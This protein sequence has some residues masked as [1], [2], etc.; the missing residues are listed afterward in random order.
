MSRKTYTNFHKTRPFD[1]MRKRVDYFE[2][3]FP[4][5]DPESS[6]ENA[7]AYE[8]DHRQRALSFSDTPHITQPRKSGRSIRDRNRRRQSYN[9]RVYDSS[10]SDTECGSVTSADVDWRRR[11]RLSSLSVSNSSIRSEMYRRTNFLKPEVAGSNIKG[12][13]R[14]P[15]PSST[16]LSGLSPT[17]AA[18]CPPHSDS[19]SSGS[20][21]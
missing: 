4:V 15:P 2:P 3:P 12:L 16:I 7:H 11:R 8:R 1:M 19:T 20:D 6:Y 9:P 21:L 14:S 5:Y 18:R 10:S 17:T 13:G